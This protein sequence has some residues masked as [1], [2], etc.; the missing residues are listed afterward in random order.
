[1]RGT[2]WRPIVVAMALT[3]CGGVDSSDGGA[4]DDD[5]GSR[6]GTT[7]G[8]VDVLDFLVGDDATW[9]RMGSQQQDQFV[10]AER[11]EI[12]WVKYGRASMFE[13][14]RW[15]DDYVYHNVDRA[16]DGDRAGQ[17]Y[18]FTDGRWLPRRLSRPW[19]L[20]MADNRLRWYLAD[21]TG[22]RGP[23]GVTIDDGPPVFPYLVKAWLEPAQDLGGDLG[24][25]EVLVL[26]YAP[27]GV[28]ESPRGTPERFRF[29]RGAGWFEWSRGAIVVKF[30]R[31]GGP[32]LIPTEP[33]L[34]APSTPDAERTT[35]APGDSLAPD[36]SLRSPDGRSVVWYQAGDGNLVL[37]T[38][39][40]PVWSTETG[41]TSPGRATMQFD[42]NFV[43]EDAAGDAVWDAH[44]WENPGASLTLRDGGDLAVELDDQTLWSSSDDD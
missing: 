39:D 9:P 41:G 3:A 19:Q 36:Q 24:T 6:P 25:R 28:G 14:W 8:D 42:G 29:A 38:D 35:L 4:V 27:H 21:C 40:E 31:L 18:H 23:E 32:D 37:Y 12:C 5:I 13:C 2:E 43:I 16:L 22:V 1:M 33:R 30:D 26:E 44:T 7:P 20:D 10:D 15:D 34:C 11:Q 17:S